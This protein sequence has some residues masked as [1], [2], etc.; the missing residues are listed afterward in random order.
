MS[1]SSPPTATSL[2][3]S[4]V[5]RIADPQN[6]SA[7]HDRYHRPARGGTGPHYCQGKAIINSINLEN[8]EEKFERI[9][10]WR[11]R[12]ARRSSSAA[13]MRTN[14]RHKPSPASASW[15]SPSAPTAAHREVRHRPREHHLRSARVSVFHRRCQLHRRSHRDHRRVRLIKERLPHVKTVLGVS[16]VSSGCRPRA[17]SRQFGLLYHWH[18]AGLD[19]AIVN[20]EKIERF[21]SIPRRNAASPRTCSS[22]PMLPASPLSPNTFARPLEKPKRP[23]PRS[24]GPAACQL[25]RRRHARRPHRRPQFETEGIRAARNHQR[26][27]HDRHG[28]SRPLFNNNEL[29]VAR[30]CN[31]PRP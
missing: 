12:T 17:R 31:Q 28:R 20:S 16:N 6:Q 30:C 22:P 10:P 29:I 24:L 8:G 3:I 15:P 1:A 7:H 25:H 19:L 11:N 26:P 4:A 18:E 13:S 27:A 9:C 2:K 21:A 5:L 23:K 14:S